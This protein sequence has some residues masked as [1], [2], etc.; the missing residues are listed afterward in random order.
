MTEVAQIFEKAIARVRAFVA[1]PH[2]LSKSGLA[3]RADLSPNAL[4]GL[5]SP[6]WNPTFRTLD[7]LIEVID[8][9]ER[10]R[11][12]PTNRPVRAALTA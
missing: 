12:R 4:R 7:R 10:A 11:R 6:D 8:D 3:K 9:I 5:D 2:G 1:S